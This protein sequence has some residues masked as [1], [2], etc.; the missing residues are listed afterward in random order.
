M[1]TISVKNF[2]PIAEGSVDLKPLTIFVGPSNTGKTY[3]A[4]AVYGIM[5]GFEGPY[6]WMLKRDPSSEERGLSTLQLKMSSGRLVTVRNGG[7]DAV[8]ALLKWA[9]QLPEDKLGP[10]QI[11]ISDTSTDLRAEMEHSIQAMLGWIAEEVIN[12]V[13]DS[14][15]EPSSFVKRDSNEGEVYL[16]IYRQDPPLHMQIPLDKQ[17][18]GIPDFDLSDGQL[19]LP[20]LES[21]VFHEILD[22]DK[23]RVSRLAQYRILEILDSAAEPVFA[24]IPRHSFYLPASR[25]GFTQGYKV[26]SSS[27]VAQWPAV[28]VDGSGRATLPK[29]ATDFL[30]NLLSIDDS[31]GTGAPNDNLLNAI[32]LIEADVLHGKINLDKSGWLPFPEITYESPTGKFTLDQTSSMVSELAPLI[33]FLKYLVHEGD[34]LILEE[35]ES[36]LHPAAQR[37][38]ARGIVRL[39]NAGVKVLITTHSDII[40]SQVN[41]LLALKQASPELIDKGGFE[42]EDFLSED[43]V[44]AYLFRHNR[45][46]RGSEVVPLEI[47]PDTGI[48]EDEFADVFEAIYDESIALQ[49]DRS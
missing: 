26:L 1:L 5:Q 2:G 4:T 34:L 21:L 17:A 40:I 37:Q 32:S 48:D 10:R 14:Y 23:D 19:Q 6:H 7:S 27:I 41:N 9:A 46:L 11:N 30:S 22:N 25:S 29:T 13:R 8:G 36:H 18:M 35:P 28:R 12:K 44:G 39:V 24:H 42:P 31:K 43:Q 15:G 16:S 49:R 3:M 47:D 20:Y 33:L 38:L 45:E